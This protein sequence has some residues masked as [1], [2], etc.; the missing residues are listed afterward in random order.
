M[1]R[2]SYIQLLSKLGAIPNIFRNVGD[3]DFMWITPSGVQK[4]PSDSHIQDISA[5]PKDF[6][7]IQRIPLN[8]TDIPIIFRESQDDDTTIVIMD[9]ETTGLDRK[10]SIIE[11]GMVRCRYDKSGEL[12]GVD[13][14]LSM[15]QEPDEPIPPE[16]TEITGITNDMVR[17]QHIDKD[18]IRRMLRGDPMVMA[19]NAEFDRPRFEQVFPNNCRWACTMIGIPWLKLGHNSK[20]L[21]TILQREGWFFD[22]HRTTEDCLAVAW[23]LHVVPNSLQTLL[24][25]SVKVMAVQAPYT[26]KDALKGNGYLWN[27]DYRCWSKVCSPTDADHEIKYLEQFYKGNCLA[28]IHEFDP[29]T[30]FK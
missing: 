11:L 4:Q 10:D 12:V 9:C 28:R 18:E 30:R 3:G 14:A 16:V 2:E 23:L 7:V 20:A 27:Q 21:G 25:P 24:A 26:A 22:A 13:E 29:R 19:H 5:R 1:M 15:F 8:Q 6:R 17:G